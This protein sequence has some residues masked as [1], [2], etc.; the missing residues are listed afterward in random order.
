MSAN[1]NTYPEDVLPDPTN[2]SAHNNAFPENVLADPTISCIPT[3][4]TSEGG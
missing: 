2:L 3:S 4:D 1:D